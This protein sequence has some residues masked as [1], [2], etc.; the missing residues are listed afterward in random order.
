[1][2]PPE[3]INQLIS[4]VQDIF[5]APVSSDTLLIPV[6]EEQLSV[7]KQTVET[8]RVLITK[9]V[10]ENQETVVLPTI[11]EEV[12]VERIP[13]NTFVDQIPDTRQEGDTT[14][15][16][17]VEE[18]AVVQKRIR[19][20]E[21]IRVTRRQRESSESQTIGLRQEF[22]TVEHIPTNSGRSV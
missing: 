8:G 12:E 22:V 16:S 5:S 3:P 15:Y 17:V 19:L 2:T 13:I 21:E 7:G 18:V 10:Q 20:V 1:M 9:T 11:R 6:I 4:P 14:I